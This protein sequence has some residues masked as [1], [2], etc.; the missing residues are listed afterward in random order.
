MS[1]AFE[2]TRID[3]VAFLPFA[4]FNLCLFVLLL[5][6]EKL[7]DLGDLAWIGFFAC[8]LIVWIACCLDL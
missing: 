1:C 7:V 2:D 6:E 5:I 3:A 4:V 8:F